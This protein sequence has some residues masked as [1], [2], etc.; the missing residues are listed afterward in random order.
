MNDLDLCIEEGH[1]NHGVTFDI[2]Y[3]GNRQR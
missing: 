2:E 1:V 3:F